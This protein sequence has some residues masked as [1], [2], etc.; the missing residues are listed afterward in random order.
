MMVKNENILQLNSSEHSVQYYSTMS[1]I[2]REYKVNNYTVNVSIEN[3]KYSVNNSQP[4]SLDNYMDDVLYNYLIHYVSGRDTYIILYDLICILKGYGS[5]IKNI[6]YFTRLYSS[7]YHTAEIGRKNNQ[8]HVNNEIWIYMGDSLNVQIHW[9][10]IDISY[11]IINLRP[12][13]IQHYKSCETLSKL[14][15]IINH[16]KCI[17]KKLMYKDI[18]DIIYEVYTIEMMKDLQLFPETLYR[19]IGSYIC[20]DIHFVIN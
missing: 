4:K 12:L 20:N 11:K 9:I 18:Y 13:H 17:E 6:K 10:E 14:E 7:L 16:T 1:I 8:F 19:I 3:N 5:K 15:F 2:H